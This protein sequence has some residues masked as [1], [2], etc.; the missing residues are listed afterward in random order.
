MVCSTLKPV[1]RLSVPITT[2]CLI[3]LMLSA[4][5]GFLCL[6]YPSSCVSYFYISSS[7]SSCLL[8]G[9][10]YSLDIVWAAPYQDTVLCGTVGEAVVAMELAIHL[11]LVDKL[12]YSLFC[13]FSPFA[14]CSWFTFSKRNKKITPFIIGSYE[15]LYMGA[16]NWLWVLWK[17][18]TLSLWCLGWVYLLG[19]FLHLDLHEWYCVPMLPVL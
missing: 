9:Q 14:C 5:V 1:V 4:K 18:E 13:F 2:L 6:L 7:N 17:M 16:G 15:S 3:M 8:Q 10:E 12:L 11:L 19:P